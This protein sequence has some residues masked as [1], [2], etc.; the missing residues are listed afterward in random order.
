LGFFLLVFKN[1]EKYE[2]GALRRK[3][4]FK[5][6]FLRKSNNRKTLK[7]HKMACEQPNRG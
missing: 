6:D 3:H 2:N 5:F 7:N 1:I 4:I